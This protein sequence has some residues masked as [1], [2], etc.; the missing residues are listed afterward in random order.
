MD[1]LVYSIAETCEHAHIGRTALYNA[2][3]AGQLRAVK[4]GRRTMILHED[5]VRYVQSLPQLEV[6]SGQ[7]ADRQTQTRRPS[8][9]ETALEFGATE[10][11]M[12]QT[13]KL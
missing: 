10:L 13:E 1:P 3:N 12:I 7:P 2:I 8:G 5:L 4:R 9:R 6:K 11:G